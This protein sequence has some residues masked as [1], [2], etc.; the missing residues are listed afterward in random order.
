MST[1]AHLGQFLQIEIRHQILYTLS[2]ICGSNHRPVYRAPT[3]LTKDVSGE[4][5]LS[6]SPSLLFAFVFF[7]S[8]WLPPFVTS[9]AVRDCWPFVFTLWSVPISRL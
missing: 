9:A 6:I 2:H 8:L 5:P 7:P 3:P 4:Y 1:R